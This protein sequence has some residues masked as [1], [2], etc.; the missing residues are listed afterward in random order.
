M[1]CATVRV[2]CTHEGT[3]PAAHNMDIARLMSTFSKGIRLGDQPE[4]QPNHPLL[5]G[6]LDDEK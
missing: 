5:L 2:W 6:Y 1:S 4:Q 3:G